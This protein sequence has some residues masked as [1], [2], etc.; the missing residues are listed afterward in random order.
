[1]TATAE[2]VSTRVEG[3]DR[4]STTA[5]Q[6][7]LAYLALA[8]AGCLW[9]TGFYFGKI[10]LAEMSVGH[11]LL[12]R[13]LFACA[14]LLPLAFKLR[15]APRREDMP[16]FLVAAALYIPLQFIV[17]FQ[18]LARTTVSHASLMVGTLPLMLALG[19]VVFT[20]ERLDRVGWSTLIVSTVG[21][22]LI[23]VQASSSTAQSGGPSLFGD[24]LV[25][26]SMLGGVGWVLLTQR[27]MHAG[28]G[29]SSSVMSVYVLVLGTIMLAAWVLATE[30][31]PPVAGISTRAWL[32]LAAQ[33]LLATTFST[34]LWNWALQHV[35][36]ARAGI[37][38]NFEP[39]VGTIL[40][41]LLLQESLGPA[42]VI[43]G[44]LI[45]GAAAVFSLRPARAAAIS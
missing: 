33:G 41:V 43:G 6:T 9:G 14:G 29:Y 21:A 42:A 45:I 22:V 11:M 36:A 15:V 16:L 8:A 24:L 27:V 26:V 31:L 25:L 38:I 23:A 44:L 28:R 12:Y 32:A 39:V 19:A 5:P 37:F 2:R 7:R 10:D 34:L 30:G 13:F 1:M 18:G 17:E 4:Q 20:H 3:H 35:P 40:G